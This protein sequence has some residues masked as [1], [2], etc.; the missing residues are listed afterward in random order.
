VTVPSPD[1]VPGG[2]DVLR[3]IELA[4]AELVGVA[5]LPLAEAAVRFAALH[6]ELQ[7]ALTDLDQV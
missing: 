5:D 3:R 4:E 1:P 6:S 7:G 2:A